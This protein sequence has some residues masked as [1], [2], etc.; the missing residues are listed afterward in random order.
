[1]PYSPFTFVDGVTPINKAAFDA[2][3]AGVIAAERTENKAAANGYP[4]L[5]GTGKVPLA[6]LPPVGA[7]LI[8]DGDFVAGNFKDGDIV[9]YQ[10]VAYICVT[11]TSAAPVAWPGGPTATPAVPVVPYGTTLP[12][13]PSDGLEAV[14][15]DSVTNPTYQWR[16][17][18]NASST[19]PYK[20]EFVGGSPLIKY[21]SV[22]ESP[23]GN[24]VASWTW[25]SP[26]VGP[27]LNAPR[28]GDYICRFSAQIQAP[29]AGTTGIVS[30]GNVS[31]SNTNIGSSPAEAL[32]ANLTGSVAG[33]SLLTGVALG[34]TMRLIVFQTAAS[35]LFGQRTFAVT[36]VRVA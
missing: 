27:D 20:W 16:F 4:S 12:A 33:E 26:T 1:M 25:C 9:V 21:I 13:S 36:P 28:A 29:A 14:L 31:V 5:D 35:T 8:Y 10:N 19:S 18:F 15:V 23:L 3:Q 17:R 32:S 2:V 30:V 24:A 34:N 6:Q 7:D 22:Q 11:P